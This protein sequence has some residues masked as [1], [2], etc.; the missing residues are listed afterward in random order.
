MYFYFLTQQ[1]HTQE[2][3]LK[4]QLNKA[5]NTCARVFPVK[6]CV[7]ARPPFHRDWSPELCYTR[8]TENCA[9]QHRTVA[10][11]TPVYWC[12][13]TARTYQHR[14]TDSAAFEVSKKEK[15]EKGHTSAYFCEN[16]TWNS[17]K[18]E[19]QLIKHA[20]HLQEWGTGW[21]GVE[22]RLAETFSSFNFGT[23]HVFI[24]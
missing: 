24:F 23:T 12:G 4:I 3:P 1:P 22:V 17:G 5:N 16:I 15:G 19:Q 14:K 13:G 21:K 6:S 8:P 11:S 20:H 9:A 18:I 7:R 10:L 2:S